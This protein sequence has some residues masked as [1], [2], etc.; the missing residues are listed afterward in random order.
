MGAEFVLIALVALMIP[1]SA[2]LGDV[3]LKVQKQKLKGGGNLDPKLLEAANEMPKLIE[4][5]KLLKRRLENVEYIVTSMDK[6][7]LQL[8]AA[9]NTNPERDIAELKRQLEEGDT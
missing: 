1:I 7:I 2:V 9:K 6:E 5:N 3:Y 8:H 4:E